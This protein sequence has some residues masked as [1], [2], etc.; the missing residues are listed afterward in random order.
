[1]LLVAVSKRDV[2][3]ECFV[4]NNPALWRRP[5]TVFGKEEAVVP[6]VTVVVIVFDR[7]FGVSEEVLRVLNGASCPIRTIWGFG[8]DFGVLTG[9]TWPNWMIIFSHIVS[10]RVYYGILRVV[11][12]D[13]SLRAE[14]MGLIRGFVEG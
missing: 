6:V 14:K 1:M 13:R 5:R 12:D 2:L 8:L 11:D 9:D 4:F 3:F 7:V 10:V